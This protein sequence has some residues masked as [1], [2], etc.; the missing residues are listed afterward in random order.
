MEE[1][2]RRRLSTDVTTEGQGN[3]IQEGPS[4]FFLSLEV[5]EGGHEPR[6]A[7]GGL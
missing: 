3:L 5:A 1:G 2:S 7:A 4:L 6:C